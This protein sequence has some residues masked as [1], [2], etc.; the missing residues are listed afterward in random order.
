MT[1]DTVE[2]LLEEFE[3]H[4]KLGYISYGGAPDGHGDIAKDV[5]N[6]RTAYSIDLSQVKVEVLVDATLLIGPFVINGDGFLPEDS[7]VTG[8]TYVLG[9]DDGERTWYFW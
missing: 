8:H 2:H 6:N 4:M 3:S 9:Y 7:T 1:G 5:D